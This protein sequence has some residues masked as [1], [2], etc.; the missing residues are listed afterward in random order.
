MFRKQNRA[1]F[2]N[3]KVT[4]QGVN[5]DSKGERDFYIHLCDLHGKNNVKLQ[6]KFLLQ[7]AFKKDGK[8]HRAITYVADF[9]I[10]SDVYDYK[11]YET[12]VFKIKRKMFIKSY[13]DL[14]LRV[15]TKKDMKK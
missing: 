10:G 5:F 8:T 2:G 11:G 14:R 9:Q 7:E 12:D 1:K 6:P 4:I 3:Q 13:P 15:V